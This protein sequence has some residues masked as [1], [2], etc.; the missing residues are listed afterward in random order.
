MAISLVS[1]TSQPSVNGNY[2]IVTSAIDTLGANLIVV[3]VTKESGTISVSDDQGNTYT[4]VDSITNSVDSIRQAFLYYVAAPTVSSSH[5]FTIT[6]TAA[7]AACVCAYS[8]AAASPLDQQDTEQGVFSSTFTFTSLTPTEDGELLFTVLADSCTGGGPS[9]DESYTIQNTI[10]EVTGNTNS[11]ISVADK[12]QTTAATTDPTWTTIN[13]L[14][15]GVLATF[16]AA[17]GADHPLSAGAGSYVLSGVAASLLHAWKVVAAAGSYLLTGTDATV[18]VEFYLAPDADVS[19]GT[20][21][22]QAGGTNLFAAID[23]AAASDADYIQSSVSPTNDVCE[24]SLSNPGETPAQP[25]KVRYRYWRTGAAGSMELRVRLLQG[26]TQIASWTHSAIGTSPV[27]AVQTL[28]GSEF[29][30]ITDFSD[31]RLEFR[32]NRT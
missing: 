28:S 16:K 12:I 24:V 29:A 18:V 9:I 20:W 17:S 27:S 8:G 22:D 32:G 21:T 25:A 3:G 30:A 6:C 7:A 26:T 5:T 11:G 31:L 19:D 1:K 13:S 2:T 14:T 15:C 10:A 4:L 23:E